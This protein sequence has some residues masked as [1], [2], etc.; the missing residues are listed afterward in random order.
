MPNKRNHIFVHGGATYGVRHFGQLTFTEPKAPSARFVNYETNPFFCKNI[1]V[2]MQWSDF[3]TFP[4]AE[5][6]GTSDVLGHKVNQRK[7]TSKAG[8]DVISLT[9]DNVPMMLRMNTT[10]AIFDYIY[11]DYTVGAP[12]LSDFTLPD[13]R[14][15][16]P[17]T[18]S[19]RS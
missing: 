11:L 3:W 4:D 18:K 15:C 10:A 6:L 19:M 12:P 14:D 8:S 9:L 13:N 16:A 2:N 7:T 17:Q 5:Y 1:T